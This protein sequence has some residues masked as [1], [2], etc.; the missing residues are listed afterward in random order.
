[1]DM[2]GHHV[3]QQIICRAGLDSRSKFIVCISVFSCPKPYNARMAL[4]MSLPATEKE[5]LP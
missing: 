5:P 3:A 2:K 4:K 1:M